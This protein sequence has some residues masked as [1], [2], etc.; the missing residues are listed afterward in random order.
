MKVLKTGSDPQVMKIIPTEYVTT[1]TLKVIDDQTL[2]EQELSPTYTVENDY[3]VITAV[4]DLKEGHYYDFFQTIDFEV[5]NQ[6]G[7]TW[8]L[9]NDEWD[10][11]PK[12]SEN[13]NIDKIFCTDQTIDQMEQD[14]YDINEDQY[15]TENTYDNEYIVI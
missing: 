11:A 7:D 4:F 14:Y 1:G 2:E 15:T 10:E 12:K 6:N 5:W 9:T 8:F 3:Q 13:L